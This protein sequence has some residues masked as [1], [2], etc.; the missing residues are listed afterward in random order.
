MLNYAH[1]TRVTWTVNSDCDRVHIYSELMYIEK[2]WDVFEINA[3]QLGEKVT[4]FYTGQVHFELVVDGSAFTAMF[5]SDDSNLYL[6]SYPGFNVTWQC[7]NKPY[8]E[9]NS[10]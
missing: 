4:H 9:F 5:S 6:D 8:G 2:D 1:N 10:R 3:T 7:T